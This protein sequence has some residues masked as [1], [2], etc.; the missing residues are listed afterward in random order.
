MYSGETVHCL[1]LVG[2]NSLLC[3]NAVEDLWV[4]THYYL[5]FSVQTIS[6][7]I[8]VLSGWLVWGASDA[9]S[10]IRDGTGYHPCGGARTLQIIYNILFFLNK[11]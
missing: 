8:P 3:I 5:S 10:P 9:V 6:S 11:K 2:W 4:N 1:M 7:F